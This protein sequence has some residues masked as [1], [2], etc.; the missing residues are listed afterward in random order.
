MHFI[1]DKYITYNFVVLF[2]FT[3]VFSA[4]FRVLGPVY[5]KVLFA[6]PK[7]NET[8][9]ID[10]AYCVSPVGVIHETAKIHGAVCG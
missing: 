8:V 2:H 1:F 3:G 6:A 7:V 10:I 5:F 4:V 9:L